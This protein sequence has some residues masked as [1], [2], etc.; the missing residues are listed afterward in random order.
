MT[1][2]SA[3]AMRWQ[4]PRKSSRHCHNKT[5]PNFHLSEN[6]IMRHTFT[7]AILALSLAA[8]LPAAHAADPRQ[9][10]G[11]PAPM[12]EHVL[13]NMRDHLVAMGEIQAALAAGKYNE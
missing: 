10:V 11:M 6:R 9:L 12:R 4:L 5:L 2:G 1:S 7:S 13:A 3:V 8:L